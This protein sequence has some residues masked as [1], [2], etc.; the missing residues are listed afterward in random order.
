[1]TSTSLQIASQP[2]VLL[3]Y[4]PAASGYRVEMEHL[5]EQTRSVLDP[6]VRIMRV[7][8]TTHPEVVT[9]FGF[10]AQPSFVLLKRGSEIWRYTGVTGSAEISS[11]VSDK[12]RQAI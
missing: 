7:S 12:L 4:I 8:E 6:A 5:L 9:S 11:Q 2:P 3:V 10:A 1:M